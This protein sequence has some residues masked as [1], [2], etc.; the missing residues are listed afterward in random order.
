MQVEPIPGNMGDKFH[1]MISRE[2]PEANEIKAT[3]DAGV[4]S[5]R[6]SGELQSILDSYLK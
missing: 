1:M 4:E 3:L 6:Q 5:M 2:H